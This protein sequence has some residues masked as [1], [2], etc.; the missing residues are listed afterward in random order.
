V[1][2]AGRV[3]AVQV[4]PSGDVT[5]TFDPVATATNSPL[6]YV[7][8][9]QVEVIGRVRSVQVIPSGEVATILVL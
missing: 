8:A 3:C 5:A 6:P 1:D 4:I 7:I 2:T 9:D